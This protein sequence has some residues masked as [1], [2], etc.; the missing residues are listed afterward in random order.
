MKSL[1]NNCTLPLLATGQL[2]ICQQIPQNTE[3]VAILY[4]EGIIQ[5]W[6]VEVFW[7]HQ[8]FVYDEFCVSGVS[9]G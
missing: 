3:N 4:V 5:V 8:P 1:I 7:V 2:L 6:E 9:G